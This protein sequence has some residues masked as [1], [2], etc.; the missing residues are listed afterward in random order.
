MILRLGTS[1]AEQ[2]MIPNKLLR[3]GIRS[4]IQRRIRELNEESK[5]EFIQELL[6]SPI[7]IATEAANE[8]HYEV[9][10]QFFELVLGGRL[11]YSACYWPDGVETLSEAEEAS[12]AQVCERA[13][14]HDGQNILDLGCGWGSFSLYAAK[15]Y[16]NA[17]ITSVSNSE[18]QRRYIQ[19]YESPQIEA[20]TADINSLDLDEKFD[21]IVSI[22]MFEHL[23]NYRSLFGRLARWLEPGG[24]VFVHVFCHRSFPYPFDT[25]GDHNWMGRYFFTGGIMPSIDLFH[26]FNEH[27]SVEAEWALDGTHYQRTAASWRENLEANRHK[28]LPVLKN[29]YRKDAEKWL[30][31]WKLFF[32]ACEELFGYRNGTEWLVGHYRFSTTRKTGYPP[33]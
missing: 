17:K 2:G 5:A 8:Q 18:S 14:I 27:L 20:L 26:C 13:D 21:R 10:S 3:W 24:K 19:S 33:A 6:S 22:E 30:H 11:K 32:L 31:R 4:L 16:P 28:L 9:T 23:R 29:V 12:L 15:H 7:A 1:L 25:I